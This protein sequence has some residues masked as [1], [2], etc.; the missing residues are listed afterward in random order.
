MPTCCEVSISQAGLK[1]VW[2][3]IL[4]RDAAWSATDKGAVPTPWIWLFNH[5][6]GLA[7]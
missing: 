1:T 7:V 5:A 3:L 4:R 6:L 2:V